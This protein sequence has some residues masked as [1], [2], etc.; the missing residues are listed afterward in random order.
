M[1][2]ARLRLNWFGYV[3]RRRIDASIRRKE[4]LFVL[5]VKKGIGTG[6]DASTAY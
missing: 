6:H 3:K 1:I 4:R 2:E 5:D